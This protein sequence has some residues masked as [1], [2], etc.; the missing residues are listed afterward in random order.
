MLDQTHT[1]MGTSDI[2]GN[3]DWK[4]SG[5]DHTS[6]GNGIVGR[7]QA[8]SR[9]TF[10]SS[11]DDT[12]VAM[13]FSVGGN[14]TGDLDEAFRLN[15]NAASA[16]A[17]FGG[18]VRLVDGDSTTPALQFGSDS[19]GFFHDTADPGQGIKMMVN[20]ANDFLFANGG[21]FHAD[22]DVIA[23][24]T[25]ISDERVKTDIEK[26]DSALD[27]VLQMRGVEYIWTRGKRKGKKDLGVIAQEVEKV[28]PEVIREKRMPLWEDKDDEVKELGKFKTVD[29]EKIVAVLI[30][31]IKEQQE[32]IDGLQN[33][34]KGIR[35]GSTW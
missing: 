6:A 32:Q 27:K 18:A 17:I 5:D 26:I 2:I 9:G 3:I 10:G 24:S 19:D 25:T 23:S 35:D 29:Y 20:N 28:L 33:Q 12:P 21:D 13:I 8:Q 7:I 31:A 11:G 16:G 4:T 30:E 34:I 15:W 1:T 22:G 14:D